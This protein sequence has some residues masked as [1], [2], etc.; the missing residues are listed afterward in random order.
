MFS[1][2]K[3]KTADPTPEQ[4][5]WITRER[6]AAR[7]YTI[8]L[9]DRAWL[10]AIANSAE[11]RLRYRAVDLGGVILGTEVIAGD[12]VSLTADGVDV[13]VADS[14]IEPIRNALVVA[15]LAQTHTTIAIHPEK[16]ERV[17]HTVLYKPDRFLYCTGD[18]GRR[19]FTTD[20][21]TQGVHIMHAATKAIGERICAR[22]IQ[23]G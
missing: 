5:D 10:R 16:A 18:G 6:A 20:E 13:I 7:L 12:T 23:I 19:V 4:T 15:S 17:R 21:A 8:H 11:Q 1:L 22:A 2:R 9:E 3:N 14:D